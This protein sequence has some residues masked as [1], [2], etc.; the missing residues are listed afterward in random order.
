[1]TV[2]RGL[3]VGVAQS[4]V[5]TSISIGMFHAPVRRDYHEGLWRH[6]AIATLCC[7]SAII[8]YRAYLCA[9]EMLRASRGWRRQ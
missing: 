8:F 7:V 4:G 9:R 5:Q 6:A 2:T 3:S 1:M